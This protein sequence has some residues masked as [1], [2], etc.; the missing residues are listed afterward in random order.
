[1]RTEFILGR[2]WFE[3]WVADPV[4]DTVST[5][6]V[7]PL[8]ATTSIGMDVARGAG[9]VTM[10]VLRSGRD[11]ITTSAGGVVNQ[12]VSR[13]LQTI[14]SDPGAQQA[15]GGIVAPRGGTGIMDKSLDL[16]GVKVPVLPLTVLA[17]GLVGVGIYAVAKKKKR[18]RR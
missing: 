6:V 12:V 13:P 4:K 11:L 16:G 17:V 10:D 5:V 18:R 7:D 15:S 3:R 9:G 8:R 1:M 14:F 2:N